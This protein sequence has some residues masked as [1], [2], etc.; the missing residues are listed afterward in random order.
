MAM[1]CSI[2]ISASD[3]RSRKK[4]GDPQRL[5][6]VKQTFP[7]LTTITVFWDKSSADQ[8]GCPASSCAPFGIRLNGIEFRGRPSDYERAIA[9]AAATGN[10]FYAGK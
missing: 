3:V 5:E 10:F 4:N 1:R 7:N 9:K 2:A 8:W 6:L